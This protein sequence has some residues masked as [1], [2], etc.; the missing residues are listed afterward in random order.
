MRE[1]VCRLGQSLVLGDP[2]QGDAAIEAPWNEANLVE[3]TVVEIREEGER[4]GH[5]QVKLGICAP[6]EVVVHRKEVWEQL[7]GA[8]VMAQTP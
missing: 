6:R 1:L 4:E 7:Q 3:V 5:A 2:A 8:D